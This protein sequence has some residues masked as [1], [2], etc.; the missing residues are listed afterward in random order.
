MFTGDRI[1]DELVE[2]RLWVKSNL[3]AY[4][5]EARKD[6]KRRRWKV[7]YR[8]SSL[9]WT[10]HQFVLHIPPEF[11]VQVITSKHSGMG[12]GGAAF[13]ADIEPLL[14]LVPVL[15]SKLPSIVT[16]SV[17]SEVSQSDFWPWV[18][19]LFTQKAYLS[20][21]FLIMRSTGPNQGR[22]YYPYIFFDLIWI[23][24]SLPKCKVP[25][26]MFD[27]GYLETNFEHVFWTPLGFHSLL[28]KSFLRSSLDAHLTL[29]HS[30]IGVWSR[31]VIKSGPLWWKFSG[32]DDWYITDLGL[33]SYVT[34][35]NSKCGQLI[36][37][38]EDMRARDHWTASAEQEEC[39]AQWK[40]RRVY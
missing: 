2:K 30:I 19:F 21:P 24:Y 15:V 8:I 1:R 32:F 7:P 29:H 40:R 16:L 14:P 13:S 36:P 12:I 6:S 31:L 26:F 11:W 38:E 33:S 39:G 5:A 25:L 34:G 27:Y 3:D 22:S 18:Y 20:V 10:F 35:I 9:Y 23:S 4:R 28:N 17:H 37:L